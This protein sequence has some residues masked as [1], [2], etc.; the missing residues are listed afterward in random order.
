MDTLHEDEPYTM[1]NKNMIVLAVISFYD[2]C[3][4]NLWRP[5]FR[6]N[7]YNAKS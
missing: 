4:H 1:L 7:T 3:T 2:D 6:S 5:L